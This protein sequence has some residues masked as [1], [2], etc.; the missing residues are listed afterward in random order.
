[1]VLL[2]AE[3]ASSPAKIPFPALQVDTEFDF[4][5]VLK[6]PD[7]LVRW[8]C[9]RPIVASVAEAVEKRTRRRIL[10]AGEPPVLRGWALLNGGRLS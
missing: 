10:P 2:L 8:P 6:T 3:K 5:E 7:D 1:M 9:A 4:P